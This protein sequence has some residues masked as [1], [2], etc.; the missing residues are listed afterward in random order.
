M[1]DDIA[2]TERIRRGPSGGVP[3]HPRWPALIC[4]AAAEPGGMAALFARNGW[5]GIWEWSVYD[6]HHWH[7][8]SHEALGVSGGAAR[9]QLGGPDGPEVEVRAGD[10]LI[11]PAG[12]GHKR[13]GATE[14]FSVVGAYPPGQ[15]NPEIARPDP[16]RVEAALKLVATV[17]APERDPVGGDA[18]PV[19]TEWRAG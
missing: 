15:E 11:L 16:G 3:N 17:P 8:E 19:R 9:L 4:R 12:F 7:P 10:V 1:D 6:F 5:G 13:V 18:G 2:R 14:D